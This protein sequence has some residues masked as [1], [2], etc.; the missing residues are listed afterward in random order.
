MEERLSLS[1]PFL[2]D[3]T[4]TDTTVE[5]MPVYCAAY[6]LRVIHHLWATQFCHLKCKFSWK[7]RGREQHKG[8]GSQCEAWK[9]ACTFLNLTTFLKIYNSPD[10]YN[11][12]VSWNFFCHFKDSFSVALFAI[13]SAPKKIECIRIYPNLSVYLGI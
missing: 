6:I 3:T 8:L 12:V 10:F 13:L 11:T 7:K 9:G 4:S 2:I 5:D 1:F